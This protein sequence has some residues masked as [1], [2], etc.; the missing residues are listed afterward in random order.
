[1]DLSSRSKILSWLREE[2]SAKLELFYDAANRFRKKQVG[3]EVHLRGLIEFS[4]HCV[5]S[6]TYCGLR[7]E[8][9][10]L[11][12]YR[13][14][15]EEILSSA[16]NAKS[17]GYGTVV[18][19]SGDDP[20]T[21]TDWMSNVIRN[22]RTETGLAVTLSVGERTREDLAAWREAGAERYLLRFETSN[23]AL[24]NRIHPRRPGQGRDRFEVLRD[25]RNLGYEVGSGVMIGIPGQTYEDLAQDIDLFRELDLDMIGVGPWISHPRAPLANM[26]CAS[27]QDQVS[28]N[29]EMVY[30]VLALT[31]L[32]CPLTNIPAT[33]GL[34]TINRDSGRELGL[35]RGANVLMPNCTPLRFRRLYEIYPAKVCMDETEDACQ[36]AMRDRVEAMGRTIGVG[37]GPS[38]NREARIRN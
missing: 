19:Q 14:T 23:K 24:F 9:R 10:D 28:N 7:V 20:R 1:M 3:D 11:E 5:C 21:T 4:N 25:L 36:S 27:K 35:D 8:N 15:P 22:I 17:A 31:R 37:P 18:L 34:A 12:R 38:R 13:M 33:T 16:R 6:C 30:K 29:E 32:V 26:P 2:D